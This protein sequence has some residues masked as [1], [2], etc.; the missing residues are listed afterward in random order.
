MFSAVGQRFLRDAKQRQRSLDMQ[1]REFRWNVFTRRYTANYGPV[2]YVILER[3]GEPEV[4]EKHRTQTGV[5]APLRAHCR[6][7][8][9]DDLLLFVYQLRRNFPQLFLQASEPYGKHGE[10]GTHVVVQFACKLC[11]LAFRDL[12][13]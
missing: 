11:A 7:E 1:R 4:V 3:D 12:E 10:Q 13:Q 2:L 5:D 6:L 9:I 8:Q